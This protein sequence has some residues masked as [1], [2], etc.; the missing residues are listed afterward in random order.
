[1]WVGLSSVVAFDGW[2]YANH[3]WLAMSSALEAFKNPFSVSQKTWHNA[4]AVWRICHSHQR[5]T[6]R[7]WLHEENLTMI[8][9]RK[10]RAALVNPRSGVLHSGEGAHR[11][12]RGTPSVRSQSQVLEWSNFSSGMFLRE[13]TS[14][15]CQSLSC[16]FENVDFRLLYVD[17]CP[18]LFWYS[19][20]ALFPSLF[21]WFF[22]VP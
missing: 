14:P 10:P 1:M 8:T 4:A 11:W 2:A 22:F 7:S 21:V 20:P 15:V 18:A 12:L 6:S 17:F 3:P 13:M 16:L 5:S 19:D 9:H